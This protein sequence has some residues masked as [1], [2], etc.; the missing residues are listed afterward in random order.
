[1]WVL[2]EKSSIV[3]LLKTESN[4]RLLKMAIQTLLRAIAMD[5]GIT[6]MDIGITAMD[7]GIA[8]MDIGIT[9]MD[10]G[11]TA[12]DIGITAMDIGITVMDTGITA[13]DIGI[14]VMGFYG[15]ERGWAPGI[16]RGQA[17]IYSQGA[18]RASGWRTPKR[19]HQE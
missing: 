13:M 8:A 7:I 11:I 4:C 14:T 12:M 10:I 15:G 19:K 3:K 5:I 16:W 6:T 9:A 18:E 1:M 2:K 17:G